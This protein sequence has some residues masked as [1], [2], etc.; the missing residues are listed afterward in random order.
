MEWKRNCP[1]CEKELFYSLEQNMKKAI[2]KNKVCRNCSRPDY[3]GKNNPFFGKKHSV[4]CKEK[5]ALE[6]IGKPNTSKTKF[7][8]ERVSGKNS[9]MHGKSLYILM[10]EKYGKE[11]AD[12]RFQKFKDKQSANNSGKGNPMYGKVTR[13]GNGYKGWYKGWFFRSLRELSYVYNLDQEG[14]K[15]ISAES[16]DF[17]IE[18]KDYKNS[19]RT[20][21]PDFLV[22]DKYL[23]EIKPIKLHTSK[24]VT[25]KKTAAEL[26]CL[27][28]PYTYIIT[29]CDILSTEVLTQLH[30]QKI[31][32]FTEK[33]ESRFA[34]YLSGH[35]NKNS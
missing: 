22:E 30:T 33:D 5:L 29:D 9:C 25:D 15:W 16:M 2:A 13:A 3:N 18:Y 20:Y 35:S 23:V 19:D 27:D 14:K 28:K 26:F 10:I 4:E 21:V 8:T 6:R 11:E 24:N 17:Y 31:I 32:K 7:I 34:T 12:L 1:K